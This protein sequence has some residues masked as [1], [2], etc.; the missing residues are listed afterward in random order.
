MPENQSTLKT[1][2]CII[3]PPLSGKS[4]Q[5]QNL[6]QDFNLFYLNVANLMSDH[7]SKKTVIG[8]RAKKRQEKNEA[9]D[10]EL[11]SQ[12]INERLLNSKNRD[13]IVF[14]GYPRN[15]NQ[16]N[17]MK[18][19]CEMFGYT[20]MNIFYL[21]VSDEKQILTNRFS[22]NFQITIENHQR[23]NNKIRK[24][25]SNVLELLQILEQEKL[26]VKIDGR[27]SI[28]SVYARIKNKNC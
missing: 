15:I 18:A 23:L 8:M 25:K 24:H 10:D 20:I 17:S 2:Y 1:L 26:L 5:A 27:G 16:Y 28:A 14:D 12:A 19:M 3:G 9:I 13:K 11:I 6:A 21:D 22:K 4:T 7:I